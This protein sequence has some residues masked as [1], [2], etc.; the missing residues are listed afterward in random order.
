MLFK[1]RWDTDDRNERERFLNSLDLG[2][3]PVSSEET[4]KKKAELLA[5]AGMRPKGD[6]TLTEQY[7]KVHWTR[8][9]DLVATRR[10]YL[11]G[12]YAYVPAREQSSIV[13]QEFSSRLERA[14]E[15]SVSKSGFSNRCSPKHVSHKPLAP[16]KPLGQFRAWTRTIAY[17]LYCS[18]SRNRFS[19][20]LLHLPLL[21]LLMKTVNWYERN[22]STS[23]QHGTSRHACGTSTTLY[24]KI[25][26]YDIMAGFSMA[27]S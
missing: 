2:M 21:R 24:A 27:Y 22:K 1:I 14:L 4:E 10:V 3:T 26:I 9:T 5:A 11:Q 12:G 15:V 7:Y 17:S 23:L 20:A 6:T 25:T 16:S 18:I 13:F 19:T 8:V